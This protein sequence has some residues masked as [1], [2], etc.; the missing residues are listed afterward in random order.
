MRASKPMKM[1]KAAMPMPMAPG[2]GMSQTAP[3]D[4]S[5]S[6]P[7][8]PGGGG[9]LINPDKFSDSHAGPPSARGAKKSAGYPSFNQNP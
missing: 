5:M 3:A 6:Q 1:G 2:G 4:M 9:F 8:S 7:Q